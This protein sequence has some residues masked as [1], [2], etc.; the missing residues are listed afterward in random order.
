MKRMLPLFHAV[1][2]LCSTNRLF[3]NRIESKLQLQQRNIMKIILLILGAWQSGNTIL[4]FPV[5]ISK[6]IKKQPHL[7]QQ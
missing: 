3:I 5:R 4:S 7:D 2:K 1:V 6:G